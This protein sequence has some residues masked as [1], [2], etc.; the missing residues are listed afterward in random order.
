M[1]SE[2]LKLVKQLDNGHFGQVFLGED[3]VQGEVAVKK[4]VPATN[5]TQ[6]QWYQ[7]KS[8][9]LSEAKLLKK[10]S[11]RNVVQVYSITESTSD[12][13]LLMVM[14]L[15]AKGSLE[16]TFKAGP[17]SI[18]FTRKVLTDITQGLQALHSRGMLHRDLKPGNILLNLNR[19]AKL[20]DF[21]LVTDDLIYGYGSIAG[22]LDHL[23]PEVRLGN[24]TSEGSDIWALGMTFYRVL[25]GAQWYSELGRPAESIPYGGYVDSLPW[26][27]HIPKEWRRFIRRCM[28]DEP[29]NRYQ[30]AGEVFAELSKLPDAPAWE[31]V[32]ESDQISWELKRNARNIKVVWTRHSPRRH[33]WKAWSE[34]LYSGRTRTLEQSHGIIGLVQAR[35]ELERFF[36][37]YR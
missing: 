18:D 25:H 3:P 23:A 19:V 36:G 30:T 2:K 16:K 33:E 31:C 4:L 34:P 12:D 37:N 1:T 24:P 21:G 32:V 22:Y 13:A 26:L 20:G 27:P 6:A 7:R 8:S 29:K 11:H 5:E 14:E 28:R 10:A 9:L 35:R 15:C 17:S